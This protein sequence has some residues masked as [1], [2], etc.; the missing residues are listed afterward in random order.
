MSDDGSS[1]RKNRHHRIPKSVSKK[2]PLDRKQRKVVSHDIVKLR[3][4][5]HAAFHCLFNNNTLWNIISLLKDWRKQ[6]LNG[7][8]GEP[9]FYSLFSPSRQAS[10]VLLFGFYPQELSINGNFHKAIDIINGPEFRPGEESKQ[11]V[12]DAIR[13]QPERSARF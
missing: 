7:N 4:D 11:I 9:L 5:R 12:I 1:C 10:F 6:L 8:N 2:L 13:S 3:V